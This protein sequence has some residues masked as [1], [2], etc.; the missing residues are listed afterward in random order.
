M[1][2]QKIKPRPL[3]DADEKWYSFACLAPNSLE[4]KPKLFPINKP[5]SV[6][7]MA[8]KPADNLSLFEKLSI[9]TKVMIMKK[10][11]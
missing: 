9:N 11:E 7:M 1:Q 2:N 5:K 10:D 8:L 6:T 3:M 4:I